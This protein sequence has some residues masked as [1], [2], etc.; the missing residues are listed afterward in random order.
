MFDFSF[1]T[2]YYPFYIDGIKNTVVLAVFTVILGFFL[3]LV[4]CLMRLSK[5][6]PLRWFAVAYIEFIRGTPV[7]LQIYII[8]Y[9]LPMI[10]IE[11]PD[12][13][14]F[15]DDFP[16]FMAG[17]IA[18]SINS[19]AYTAEIIR[20]GIQSVDLGQME[21]ARS[22]GMSHGMSMKK[23]VIPQAIRNILPALG[24]EFVIIIKES[25]IVSVIGIAEIMYQSSVLRGI[26]YQPLSPLIVAAVLYFI[27][28]FAT[29]QLLGLFERRM[30][31]NER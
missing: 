11:F 9:C 29:S 12:I 8:F 25:S 26:T 13:P 20:S 21:A 27:L 23:I 24:N 1:F 31:R 3:G 19:S 7:I 18:L 16:R 15:G 17:V 28:T 4:F 30:K 2:K 5:I 6:H 14:L 22:L 10:G